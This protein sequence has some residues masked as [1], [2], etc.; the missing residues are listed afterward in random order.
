MFMCRLVA[1]NI[2]LAVILLGNETRNTAE[3]SPSLHTQNVLFVARGENLP[4]PTV[5]S[6]QVGDCP[7]VLYAWPTENGQFCLRL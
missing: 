4:V 1:F 3:C 6:R 7:M 2:T 5:P